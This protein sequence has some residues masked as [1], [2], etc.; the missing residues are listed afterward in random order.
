M[1]TKA[2]K[3]VWLVAGLGNPGRQYENSWHNTGY[4]VLDILA[5]RHHIEINRRRCKG[6]VGQG[7]ISDQK[8]LLL[9]PLT[10]MNLSG[11]SIRAALAFYK[12]APASCL[13]IYDDVDIPVGSIRI[14]ET[15]SAGTHNGMRSVV[16]ALGHGDF[17]RIRVGIGPQ[18][19]QWDIVDYVLSSIPEAS[20]ESYRQ[21]LEKAADAA[22][23]ILGDSLA[24]A[25]NQ[26]NRK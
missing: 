17:P 25:M 1:E 26:F 3:A 2:G 21:S 15:G 4:Q 13:V 20:L 11:E 18:P 10:Y 22:E 14:K 12:I 16:G 6:L 23:V 7:T 19:D 24:R 9:K 8:C 5:R